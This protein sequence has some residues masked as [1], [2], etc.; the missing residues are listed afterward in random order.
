MSRPALG[1]LNYHLIKEIVGALP[2]LGK[3]QLDIRTVYL[4]HS[5]KIWEDDIKIDIQSIG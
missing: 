1:L 2:P 4:Y 3:A 5:T